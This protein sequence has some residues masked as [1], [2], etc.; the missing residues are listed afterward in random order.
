MAN[1][2]ADDRERDRPHHDSAHEQQ[3]VPSPRLLHV[4]EY[5]ALPQLAGG[6]HGGQQQEEQP[7]ASRERHQRRSIL[8]ARRVAPA[9][10]IVAVL[11]EQHAGFR[12]RHQNRR[13]L[14]EEPRDRVV[15]VARGLELGGVAA[16]RPRAERVAARGQRLDLLLGHRANLGE[17]L[18]QR[19]R[20][21]V[22]LVDRRELALEPQ[23]V[24]AEVPDAEPARADLL[25]GGRRRTLPTPAARAASAAPSSGMASAAAAG[26]DA[27][28]ALMC[29][30]RALTPEPFASVSCAKL[31]H[32]VQE[33]PPRV[34]EIELALELRDSSLAARRAR[35]FPLRRA[36]VA[37]PRSRPGSCPCGASRSRWSLCSA[38]GEARRLGRLLLL[39]LRLAA[40]ELGVRARKLERE[41]D[42][43][44]C[45]LPVG[46][47]DQ[48]VARLR[49]G[50]LLNAEHSV[51][52][53]GLVENAD[54]LVARHDG[55]RGQRRRGL[56]GVRLL[57]MDPRRQGQGAT[58]RGDSLQHGH[59]G[60]SVEG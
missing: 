13:R 10:E 56:R 1:A 2:I 20:A 32:V 34:H 9:V 48:Q 45:G 52:V 29:S 16:G 8:R 23:H 3:L 17:R 53:H 47:E 38:C 21:A 26:I 50:L 41:R 44:V 12:Q 19:F 24:G 40:Q 5:G 25:G 54:D 59:A 4:L 60:S 14:R 42:D 39:H 31:D 22:D 33:I 15:L 49:G 46:I 43:A 37:W 57:G 6:E 7:D 30:L 58:N 51:P 36:V 28:M 11:I 55:A 27:A 18:L 35:R